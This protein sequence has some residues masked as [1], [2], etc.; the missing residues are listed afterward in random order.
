MNRIEIDNLRLRDQRL[1]LAAGDS[2]TKGEDGA[3]IE[4]ELLKLYLEGDDGGIKVDEL[5]V[6]ND[7]SHSA[8]TI[9]AGHAGGRRH[10]TRATSSSACSISPFRP[11][12]EDGPAPQ[13]WSMRG[14]LDVEVDLP[15]SSA[16][17]RAC[18]AGAWRGL[19]RRHLH[20][21]WRPG[22]AGAGFEP[23]KAE[24]RGLQPRPV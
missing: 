9:R 17:P 18:T 10:A 6:R 2:A 20:L 13:P 23:A 5:R 24:P 4:D 22:M 11:A 7:T 8:T 1:E 3:P 16:R 19:P 12:Q 14:D 15:H 21:S